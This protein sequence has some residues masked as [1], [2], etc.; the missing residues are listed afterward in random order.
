MVL[1]DI[2][3][4]IHVLGWVFW[5]G[6][7]I[8]VFI[9]VKHSERPDLGVEARMALLNVGMI[10]DRAPR[11]AV[12][13]VWGTGALMASGLGYSFMPDWAIVAITAGWG[14]FVW[15]GIFQP[16]GSKL[17]HFAM[18]VLATNY[19]VWIVWMGGGGAYLLSI[20]EIPLWLAIKWFAY[21]GVAI[22][23]LLLEKQFKPAVADYMTLAEEGA[24]DELNTRLSKHMAPVYWSV[25]AIYVCTLVAGISGLLKPLL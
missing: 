6:T 24:S 5:F 21:V 8:G 14:A 20:G 18:Q 15:L 2:L 22:A 13:V 23:A 10:L 16:P 3:L 7:D 11:F 1:M 4:V 17:Q 9:A 25:I 12:P 19:L